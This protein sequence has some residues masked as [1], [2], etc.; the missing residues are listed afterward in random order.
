MAYTQNFNDDDENKNQQAG[1]EQVLASSQGSVSNPDSGPSPAKQ[2]KPT[3]SGSWTNLQQYVTANDGNDAQMGNKI[4]SGVEQRANQ[5]SEMGNQYSTT[6]S[7]QIDQGTVRDQGIIDAVK[8][9]PTAIT[10]DEQKR[11]QFDKQ[12]DAYYGGPQQTTDIEGYQQAGQQYNTVQDRA[13]NAQTQQGRQALLQDEYSRPNYTRGENTLDSFVL[14]AGNQ[15]RQVLGDINREYGNYAQG[16]QG[17]LDQ[18]QGNIQQGIDTTNQTREQTRGATNEGIANYNQKFGNYEQQLAQERA[19]WDKQFKG[20]KQDLNKDRYGV[21]GLDKDV[22]KWLDKSGLDLTSLVAKNDYRQLGDFI[23]DDEKAAYKALNELGRI[24]GSQ[25][26]D[27]SK[28]GRGA[29]DY[30]RKTGLYDKGQQA[31]DLWNQMTAAEKAEEEKR[32]R[33]YDRLM[34]VVAPN[35]TLAGRSNDDINWALDQLGISFEDMNNFNMRG[36]DWGKYIDPTIDVSKSAVANDAQRKAWQELMGPLATKGFNRQLGSNNM[37]RYMDFDMDSF[38]ADLPEFKAVQGGGT[39][40]KSNNDPL[41]G[42]RQ[43]V[44]K[45]DPV[46]N[47]VNKQKKKWGF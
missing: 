17:I 5:A 45:N 44:I 16:W 28:T 41:A 1:S 31:Y 47:Q 11:A 21:G 30:F 10:Q 19:N 6:A 9:S 13:Q 25:Y 39:L 46:A 35:S 36:G 26:Q 24:E 15:G 3:S 33:E 14:G 7:S 27:F 40:P 38:L 42:L 12:W 32:Q 29:D 37:G 23:N 34:G 8:T 43:G 2:S 18:V 22:A 20:L 4:K